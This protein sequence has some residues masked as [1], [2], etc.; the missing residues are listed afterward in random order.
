MIG[1]LDNDTFVFT[2]GGGNDTVQDFA[3]GAGVG[4]TIDLSDFE[5][6]DFAEAM[7]FADD[8]SGSVVF[9]FG[10][11]TLTLEN[12]AFASKIVEDDLLLA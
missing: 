4:D 1:G 8:F 10:S 2:S 11:D 9:N 3:A 7:S 12:V 6:G 5:F